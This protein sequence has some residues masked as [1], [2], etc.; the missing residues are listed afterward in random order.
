MFDFSVTL[1][2]KL[3][4]ASLSHVNVLFYIYINIVLLCN[5]K[6]RKIQIVKALKEHFNGKVDYV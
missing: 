3:Y 5:F 4:G 6:L 1:L 2:C